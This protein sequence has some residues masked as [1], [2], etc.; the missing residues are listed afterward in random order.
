MLGM[1]KLQ[2]QRLGVTLRLI[3]LNE[4]ALV[5]DGKQDER[6]HHRRGEQLAQ[7]L[8][9]GITLPG[10][11]HEVVIQVVDNRQRTEAAPDGEIAAEDDVD[12]AQRVPVKQQKECVAYGQVEN[13]RHGGGQAEQADEKAEPAQKLAQGIGDDDGYRGPVPVRMAEADQIRGV[14]SAYT[15]GLLLNRG[16]IEEAGRLHA[17]RLE[18]HAL[19]NQQHRAGGRPEPPFSEREGA[20]GDSQADIGAKKEDIDVIQDVVNQHRGIT[21]LHRQIDRRYTVCEPADTAGARWAGCRLR[22]ERSRRA[23]GWKSGGD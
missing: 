4:L 23:T 16:L 13:Q 21:P 8:H 15:V 12:G 7:Q 22:P 14:D 20:Q 1:L 18:K 17:L 2:L 10:V 19:K 9:V 5:D 3:A 6:E 11:H